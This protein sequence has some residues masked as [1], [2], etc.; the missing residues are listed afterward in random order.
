MRVIDVL[1]SNKSGALKQIVNS[2]RLSR[3]DADFCVSLIVSQSFFRTE[4]PAI[5]RFLS[6]LSV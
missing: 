6:V 5:I 3:M 2:N 1:V 4:R